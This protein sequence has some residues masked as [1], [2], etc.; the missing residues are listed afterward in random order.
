M[1]FGLGIVKKFGK[2]RL[3]LC[4]HKT[5]NDLAWHGQPCQAKLT[6]VTDS[7]P[8][9]TCVLT[10]ESQFLSDWAG[11]LRNNDLIYYGVNSILLLL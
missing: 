5:S 3:K 6:T 1:G 11:Y 2:R 9:K 10:L 4:A 8:P 7:L